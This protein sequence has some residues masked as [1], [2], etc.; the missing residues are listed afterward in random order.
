MRDTAIWLGLLLSMQH[1]A[2]SPSPASTELPDIIF[3]NVSNIP[4]RAVKLEIKGTLN[5]KPAMNPAALAPPAERFY[6][7][8][9]EI[10]GN[11][12]LDATAWDSDGCLR[13][14]S[15]AQVDLPSPLAEV[16]LPVAAESPRKCDGIPPC[17]AGTVCAEQVKPTTQTLFGMFAISPTDIWA[18]GAAGTTIHYDGTGWQSVPVPAPNNS[19]YLNAVWGSGPNDVWAVGEVGLILH[20]NGTSWAVSPSSA[21]YDLNGIWGFS[22]T[23][24]V[25][26]GSQAYC[27]RWNGSAWGDLSPAGTTKFYGIWG[28]SPT[29]IWAGGA[30]G[31]IYHY[32]GSWSTQA[33]PGT[34]ADLTSVWGRSA[35]EIY[36]GGTSGTIL[37][38]NG[39][40]WTRLSSSTTTARLNAIIGDA[41]GVYA[42]GN[43]GTFMQSVVPPYDVFTASNSGIS[44]GLYGITVAP[45]GFGWIVGTNGYLGRYD[46]RP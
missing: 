13:G 3:V 43:N 20:Y 40:V 21:M 39:S 32:T 11:L 28:S 12:T 37:R 7:R 24:I 29:D 27:Y 46:A 33:A 9:P 19:M 35:S 2:C 31:T 15:Q 44:A 16:S 17:G 34:T 45:S 30:G 18:V 22:P 6:M 8:L 23:N 1:L 41:N 5:G 25:T 36:M 4:S 38:Y 42:V 10:A 26:C 14:T